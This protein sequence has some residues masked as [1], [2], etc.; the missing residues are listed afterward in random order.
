MTNVAENRIM[1]FKEV[2]KLREKEKNHC[3]NTWDAKEGR[4]L[5]KA[6]LDQAI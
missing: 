3:D 5:A 6:R 4:W 2:Q 1:L